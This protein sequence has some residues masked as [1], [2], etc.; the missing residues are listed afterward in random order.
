M[1]QALG[2][3]QQ[4]PA[5]EQE[6]M[7]DF[8][9]RLPPFR[10]NSP[11]RQPQ[12]QS[13]RQR[14]QRQ[15]QQTQQQTQQQP[16]QQRQRQQRQRQQPRRRSTPR[17][18]LWQRLNALPTPDNIFDAHPAQQPVQPAIQ[19]IQQEQPIQQRPQQAQAQAEQA[20]LRYLRRWRIAV[21]KETHRELLFASWKEAIKQAARG[22]VTFRK[23]Q[24]TKEQSQQ[25]TWIMIN[26]T[27][28]LVASDLDGI[29]NR[30]FELLAEGNLPTAEAQQFWDDSKDM[31][32]PI[33]TELV[34]NSFRNRLQRPVLRRLT[35]L[36]NYLCKE[37]VKAN[38]GRNAYRRDADDA[39]ISVT[40][41]GLPK[42]LLAEPGE[43][44]PKPIDPAIFESNRYRD[45]Q[46][47]VKDLLQPIPVELPMPNQVSVTVVVRDPTQLS[48]LEFIALLSSCYSIVNS[49]QIPSFTVA[50]SP[51]S[52]FGGVTRT[53]IQLLV[54]YLRRHLSRL[55][56]TDLPQRQQ[57]RQQSQG[58]CNWQIQYTLWWPERMAHLREM[59]EFLAGFLAL[60]LN[61]RNQADLSLSIG[62]RVLLTFGDNPILENVYFNL[63]LYALQDP[64]ATQALVAMMTEYADP[65]L[66]E[67]VGDHNQTQSVQRQLGQ[68][69]SPA[70]RLNWLNGVLRKLLY[71]PSGDRAEMTFILAI[72]EALHRSVPLDLLLTIPTVFEVDLNH[73]EIQIER[74]LDPINRRV[75]GYVRQYYRTS[76][77]ETKRQ[78]LSFVHGTVS[79]KPIIVKLIKSWPTSRFPEA[80]TCFGHLDL[81]PY[82]SLA[83]FVDKL[84]QGMA[85]S[86]VVLTTI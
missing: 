21:S 39:D 44:P 8:V 85:N 56:R 27:R 28:A 75:A 18:S 20:R 1:R 49:R 74:P 31:N 59:P 24:P 46:M 71:Y 29:E 79:N 10:A 72:R 84:T 35:Q 37:L 52:D 55:P 9:A 34:A 62:C 63:A 83:E 11:L 14:Q 86:G 16:R 43:N 53:I 12:R 22:W 32:L 51:G 54:G 50:N 19:Q 5:G 66:T 48:D 73:V 7:N 17:R 60:V 69:F 57:Q 26:L 77:D 30:L 36:L 81:P 67:L 70:K 65:E 41:I 80:H 23:G 61:T 2:R 82:S 15:R 40:V 25:L 13:Q 47:I 76:D 68:R 42:R 6:P 45:A 38:Y 4:P 33:P 3:R 58:A 78:F 64:Q